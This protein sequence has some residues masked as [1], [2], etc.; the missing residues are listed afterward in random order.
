[1]SGAERLQDGQNFGRYRIVRLIGE[2][3]MGTVYEAVHIGLKKRFAIKTLL[4]S[5]AQVE[6]AR[7]R[8]L[9]EGEAAATISHPNV[10]AV[11]DVGTEGGVPYLVME[12]LEGQTLGDLLA[13]RGMLGSEEAVGLLLPVIAAVAAG[14]DAG[15]IHRD[16]K[17]QNIFLARGR[18]GELTPKVLDFG[19][20]KFA[21]EDRSAAITQTMSVLGTAPYMSPEQARGAKRVEFASDQYAL[22]LILYEMLTGQRAHAGEHP[23]E[24]LHNVASRTIRPAREVLPSLPPALDAVLSRMLAGQPGERYLSLHECGRALL[25]LADAGVRA[26]MANGFRPESP[27]TGTSASIVAAGAITGAPAAITGAPAAITGAPAA[28]T[29]G[30]I[31][32]TIIAPSGSGPAAPTPSTGGAR[33]PRRAESLSA[34]APL[35]V[36]TTLRHATGEAA[37]FEVLTAAAVAPRRSGRGLALLGAAV[38]VAGAAIGGKLLL[39]RVPAAR[40]PGA[41]AVPHE[42]ATPT[43]TPPRDT[44][45][46]EPPSTTFEIHA[47]PAE[48]QIALDERAPAQGRLELVL[49]LAGASHVLRVSAPGYVSKVVEFRGADTPPAEIEL[50][51]VAAPAPRPGDAPR[52]RRRTEGPRPAS[53]PPTIPP[54]PSAARPKKNCDPNFYLDAQGEKHFKPECFLDSNHTP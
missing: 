2:G 13:A 48:A 43:P 24:I 53:A 33:G 32:S 44:P 34:Q 10:V 12:Y 26:S 40:S 4:P 9:R 35:P 18:Y 30:K 47:V 19:V 1:M 29:T 16:L 25:Q 5:L 36:D 6:E 46:A 45:P 41:A 7:L 14:H 51:R 21:R 54:P 15:V 31:G 37:R 17:P 38:V 11:T 49:P 50:E 3:G 27:A 28:I 39:G 42:A 22:G 8:F 52:P 20:S 23:L